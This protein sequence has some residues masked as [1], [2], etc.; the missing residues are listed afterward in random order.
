MG[1]AVALD[2]GLI[3]PV[4]RSAERLGVAEIASRVGDLVT[5][6][7]QNSLTPADVTGGTFTITNLGMLGIDHFTAI[8]NQPESAI[9]AVGRIAKRTVVVERDGAD[10]VVVRPMMNMALSADHRVLDGAVAA[11]FL[12]DVVDALEHPNLLLW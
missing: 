2:E 11:R 7:R 9:L 1:V 10:E 3:V 6:A 12:R 4:V 5:R 8:I